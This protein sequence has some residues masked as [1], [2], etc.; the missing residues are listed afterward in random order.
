MGWHGGPSLPDLSCPGACWE[1][2]H[3]W[4][5]VRNVTAQLWKPPEFDSSDCSLATAGTNQHTQ[6]HC[7][8]SGRMGAMGAWLQLTGR[9]HWANSGVLRLEYQSPTASSGGSCTKCKIQVRRS[10][11]VPLTQ[12]DLNILS[13]SILPLLTDIQYNAHICIQYMVHKHT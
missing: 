12:V 2:G 13:A 4:P 1:R 7:G 11:H 6:C 10:W 3:R 5:V 9:W 8:A